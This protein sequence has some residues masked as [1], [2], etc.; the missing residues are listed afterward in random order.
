[1]T[2]SP[3]SP[4]T[5]PLPRPADPEADLAEQIAQAELR[6]VAREERLHRR[7]DSISARVRDTIAQRRWMMSA[8]ALATASLTA[9][10][11]VRRRQTAP[12]LGNDHLSRHEGQWWNS[13]PWASIVVFLWPILPARWRDKLSPA[14]A[15]TAISTV[16]PFLRRLMARRAR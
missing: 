15:S 1:M 9:F 14:T 6:L 7:F 10:W 16:M 2:P 5:A 3:P 4:R 13:L 12:A 8:A 11:L